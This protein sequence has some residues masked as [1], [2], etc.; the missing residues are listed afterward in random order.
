MEGQE[1][2]FCDVLKTGGLLILFMCLLLFM[3]LLWRNAYSCFACFLVGILS[4]VTL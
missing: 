2:G 3:H 1:A 4:F